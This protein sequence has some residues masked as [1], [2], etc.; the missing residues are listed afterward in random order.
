M[1]I[2]AIGLNLTLGYAGQV[3][4]AQGAFVGIGAYSAAILT[5]HGW[6]L[7]AAIVAR[8][9]ALL[10]HRLAARLS[11]AA[12]AAPL[13]RLRDLGVL[14]ARLPRLPQRG[15]ADRTAPTA[16]TACRGRLPRHVDAPSRCPTTISACSCSRSSTLAMLGLVRSPWGRAF[17]ALR[18]NPLRAAVARRRHAALYADGFRDRLGARRARRRA[19]SRRW[20]A[21]SSRPPSR[22][23][24]R[25]IC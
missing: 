19:L 15:L 17:I 24:C 8:A 20:S 6:P 2:A 3:S 7:V 10:R 1:T 12:R 14:D 11:R 4:L 21:S 9:R 13:S 5:T 18:E 16:S 23:R 22:S 25:S